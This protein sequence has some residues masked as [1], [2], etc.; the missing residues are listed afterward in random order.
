[1]S[2]CSHKQLSVR[3]Y[4]I[5]ISTLKLFRGFPEKRVEQT[6][7]VIKA[8]KINHIPKCKHFKN[9]G[10]LKKSDSIFRQSNSSTFFFVS[11]AVT[12]FYIAS[13]FTKNF[14]FISLKPGNA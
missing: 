5:K 6:I 1:M 7:T 13:K 14:S 3:N 9:R 11:G 4:R 2:F 12:F 10:A 8:S